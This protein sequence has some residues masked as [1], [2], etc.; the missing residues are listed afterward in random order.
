MNRQQQFLTAAGISL[1]STL[2][3]WWLFADLPATRDA[4][5]YLRDAK[6]HVAGT[7]D[8]PAWYYPPGLTYWLAMLVDRFGSTSTAVRIN[9]LALIAGTSMLTLAIGRKLHRDE[10]QSAWLASLMAALYPPLL[11]LAG[12]PYPQHLSLICLGTAALCWMNALHN[13]NPGQEQ[14]PTL[15]HLQFCL[16]GAALGY[17]ALTRPAA[18]SIGLAMAATGLHR[19]FAWR[20]YHPTKPQ[21]ATLACGAALTMAVAIL[22][23]LPTVVHNYRGGAGATLSINNERNFWLGNNPH[24]PHYKTS[25]LAQRPVNELPT[26]VQ[27]YLLQFYIRGMTL[28]PR[29]WVEVQRGFRAKRLREAWCYIRSRPDIFLLRTFNRARAFW[30][31]DYIAS[32]QIQEW[33]NWS[34]SQA[35]PLYALEAGG[36]C[37]VMLLALL[38]LLAGKDKHDAQADPSACPRPQNPFWKWGMIAF[39]LAYQIPYCLAFSAGTYHFP[40]MVLLLPFAGVGLISLKQQGPAKTLASW[41]VRLAVGIFLLIQLEYAYFTYAFM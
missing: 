15:R 29:E 8:F 26:E 24:T 34:L 9:A 39:V 11:L 1:L 4:Y 2:L 40:A 41:P 22:T 12:Q 20:R 38:G 10:S 19:L 7:P 31:F 25:N 32:R 18:L 13:G 28:A 16:A 33:Q 17:G 30:G 5:D 35:A 37:A 14:Q 3:V 36:Y 6:L 27:N 23:I 21:T